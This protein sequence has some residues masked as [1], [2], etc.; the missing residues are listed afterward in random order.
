MIVALIARLW[1]C[2]F[3]L[4]QSAWETA[5]GGTKVAA[6][7][8]AETTVGHVAPASS[9]N[10]V[11]VLKASCRCGDCTLH[12]TLVG[13]TTTTPPALAPRDTAAVDCHCPACRQYHT[14]AFC[15]LVRARISIIS[16][17]DDDNDIPWQKYRHTCA[18]LGAVN[19][20]FCRR[21]YAKLA[22]QPVVVG[23]DDKNVFYVNMG[24]LVDESIQADYSAAWRTMRQRWQVDDPSRMAPWYPAHPDYVEPKNDEADK[25]ASGGQNSLTTDTTNLEAPTLGLFTLQGSCACGQARYQIQNWQIPNHMPHCYCHVCRRSSGSAFLSWFYCDTTRFTWLT[26][27]PLRVRTTDIA[28]RHVCGNCSG[29]LTVVYDDEAAETMWPSVGSIDDDSWRKVGEYVRQRQQQ[30]QQQ[31]ANPNQ[32]SLAPPRL[33]GCADKCFS[34]VSHIYCAFRPQWYALPNDGL[35]RWD[36]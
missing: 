30:Q 21:C 17:S 10:N 22:T 3:K 26:A 32:S 1:Q 18:Q 33:G 27:E 36:E 24:S 7:A 12:L 29:N 8:T 34:D 14:S 35:P 6:A 4:W 15:S 2:L 16:S 20:Y 31:H 19:R 25:Q 9:T 11:P 5:R 23:N 28:V 13:S